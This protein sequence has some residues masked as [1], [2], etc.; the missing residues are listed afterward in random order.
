MLPAVCCGT[1]ISRSSLPAGGRHMT[2][3]PLNAFDRNRFLGMFPSL[4]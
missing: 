1:C 4:P 3:I 2:E